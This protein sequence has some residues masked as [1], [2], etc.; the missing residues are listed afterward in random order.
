MSIAACLLLYGLVVATLGPRLLTRWTRPGV[1]PR[2]GVAVWLVAIISVP[3]SWAAAAVLALVA[4]TLGSHQPVRILDSCLAAL[5]AV[6]AGDAGVA[7][8]AGL[9]ALTTGAVAAAGFLVTRIVRWLLAARARTHD[10]ARMARMAGREL[11]GSDAVVVES[12]QRL[13]YCV[14]GRPHAIV[15]SQGALDTLDAPH[16]AAVLAHERAHLDGRHHL[17]LAA[18]RG[19]AGTLPKVPLFTTGAAE[20]A[21]LL[22]MCADDTAARAHGRQTVLGALLALSGAATL[23]TGALGATGVGVLDRAERLAEP[24]GFAQRWRA[25]ALLTTTL[26]L[27][28]AGPVITGALSAT[29]LAFCDPSFAFCDPLTIAR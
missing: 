19:L 12:P 9:F 10:H 16:L 7:L 28:T 6:A 27:L 13:A 26:A 3:A 4:P 18:T 15:V 22:E 24:V 20:V 21:R 8:Q 14:A 5:E 23:P 17:V 2:L 29:G 11:P 1:A 25:R